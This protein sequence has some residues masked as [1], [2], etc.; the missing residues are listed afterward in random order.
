[1]LNGA[2]DT[3]REVELRS[4][5]AAGLT[6]LELGRRVARIAGRSAGADGRAEEA[7][8]GVEHLGE[9]LLERTAAG[10]DDLGLAEIGTLALRLT[11]RDELDALRGGILR[12]ERGVLDGARAAAAL[13]R[14]W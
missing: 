9:L 4:D 13:G 3:D 11:E 2:G 12:G 1:M 5:D 10:D 7:G 14:R 6:D 8:E